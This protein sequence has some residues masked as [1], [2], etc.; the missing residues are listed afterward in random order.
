[1]AAGDK[2]SKHYLTVCFGCISGENTHTQK[3]KQARLILA[4]PAF[5][6]HVRV[7]PCHYGIKASLSTQQKPLITLCSVLLLAFLFFAFLLLHLLSFFFPF[8][9]FFLNLAF[10]QHPFFL[11]PSGF[12]D[13]LE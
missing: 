12:R 3:K 6:I 11:L 8:P 1:M 7:P 4:V 10:F 5:H 9:F 13:A 2:C